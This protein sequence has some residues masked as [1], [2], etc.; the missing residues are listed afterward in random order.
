M[1]SQRVLDFTVG[2]SVDANLVWD[3]VKESL[4]ALMKTTKELISELS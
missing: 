3:V 1:A 4:P 2:V